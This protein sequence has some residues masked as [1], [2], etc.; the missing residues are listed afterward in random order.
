MN[1]L[2][3]IL[4]L[5]ALA[6]TAKAQ[7]QS[8]ELSGTIT[9]KSAGTIYLTLTDFYHE[10]ISDSTHIVDGKFVLKGKI[11]HPVM[12]FLSAD[13]SVLSVEKEPNAISFF[14]D[15]GNTQAELVYNDFKNVI[16]TGAVTNNELKAFEKLD[17]TPETAI[18]YISKHPN[19]FLSVYLL[20]RKAVSIEKKEALFSQ[21]SEDVKQSGLGRLIQRSIDESKLGLP[22]TKAIDFTAVDIQGETLSLSDYRGK[23]VLIDFWASWCLP[24]RAGHPHLLEL[25]AKYKDKGFE[26]I[27]V[28][29]DD[30]NPAVWR[31]AVE[32]DK[33]GVWKHILRGL[34]MGRIKKGDTNYNNYP[35]EISA[36]RYGVTSLP[37]KVLVNPE[38]MIIGRYTGDVEAFEKQLEEIFG[39]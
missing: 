13:K 24:C 29:D 37:T 7:E 11:P 14:L 30:K 2:L 9:G 36:G 33:V 1:R 34:D 12:A 26:I 16:L 39:L 31:N 32:K 17:K 6:F 18:D 23:Y 5:F 28:A 27:S 10:R 21:L 22:G 20:Q 25:Y 35:N 4:S 38:G 15:P 8:F 19:S 3:L